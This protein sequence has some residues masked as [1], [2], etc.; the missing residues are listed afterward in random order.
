MKAKVI[1]A[2]TEIDLEGDQFSEDCL[3]KVAAETDLP[4]PMFMDF[5]KDK[6]VGDVISLRYKDGKLIGTANIPKLAVVPGYMFDPKEVEDLPDGTRVIK[7]CV[8]LEFGLTCNPAD[9][10][11]KI[12]SI[13][14]EE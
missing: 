3:K 14:E 8:I 7:S 13:E 4:Q 11:C 6:R 9:L 5:K 2:T 10:N 1:L 12:V